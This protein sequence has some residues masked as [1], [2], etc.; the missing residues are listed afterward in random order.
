MS[1]KV[2]KANIHGIWGNERS[3]RIGWRSSCKFDEA[4]GGDLILNMLFEGNF[5]EFLSKGE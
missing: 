1:L 4:L 3:N 2:G 5:I